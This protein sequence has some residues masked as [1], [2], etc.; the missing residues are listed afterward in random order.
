MPNWRIEP[1]RT[2]R[3]QCKVCHKPIKE[4]EPRFGQDEV[5]ASWF[6]LKCAAKGA[7]RA[8]KPF[9]AQA[10]EILAH[11]WT[12]VSPAAKAKQQLRNPK[13]EAALI[14]APTDEGAQAVYGDWLQAQ[15]DWWGELI[16]LAQTDQAAWKKAMKGR[17]AELTGGLSSTKWLWFAWRGGFVWSISVRDR[18]K[19]AQV[20]PVLEAAFSLRAALLLQEVS[21]ES[22]TG[23]EL[24]EFLA[25]R[26]PATV[27]T[28]HLDLCEGFSRLAGAGLEALTI[29]AAEGK[30]PAELSRLGG[31]NRL[32]R[33]R[34]IDLYG[35]NAGLL[36]ALLT[37]PASPKLE[38]LSIA[39]DLSPAAIDVLLANRTRLSKLK[40]LSYDP[41]GEFDARLAK[42]FGKR[43]E[44]T[45]AVTE[46]DFEEELDVDYLD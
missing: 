40:S 26:L 20:I 1:A 42:A 6:H 5:T 37:S 36:E 8:F 9:A 14:A 28:L 45:G 35:G 43:L 4:G 34:R 29:D 23:P 17:L 11:G 15:G 33:L 12:S 31:S 24:V 18:R 7:P 10:A 38:V 21:F 39:G 19:P 13:L 27:A 44:T 30:N 2:G 46:R 25:A 32:P 41:E 22:S 16:V 3:G